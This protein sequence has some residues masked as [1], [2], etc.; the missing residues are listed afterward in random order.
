MQKNL[1]FC[2]LSPLSNPRTQCLCSPVGERSICNCMVLEFCSPTHP[3][4]FHNELSC[5]EA[6]TASSGHV[7]LHHVEL[8]DPAFFPNQLS[9]SVCTWC[10]ANTAAH[11]ISSGDSL[12]G[13]LV[14]VICCLCFPSFK[15]HLTSPLTPS[16]TMAPVLYKNEVALPYHQ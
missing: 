15:A 11:K 9:I 6:G 1:L 12:R 8:S 5:A 10:Q 7:F 2:L 14:S 13:L 4:A 3:M 16:S